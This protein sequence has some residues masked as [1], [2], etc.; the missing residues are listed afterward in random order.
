MEF[1]MHGTWDFTASASG[2]NRPAIRDVNIESHD[3]RVQQNPLG[4]VA[5]NAALR[6]KRL[7]VEAVVPRLNIVSKVQ[8]P[9]NRPF[10]VQWRIAHG[11]PRS[12]TGWDW[13][14]KTGS[15]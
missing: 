6:E 14:Q 2:N 11:N 5:I 9:T 8:L 10:A 12:F 7:T 1:L 3:F 13:K 15:R 4:S